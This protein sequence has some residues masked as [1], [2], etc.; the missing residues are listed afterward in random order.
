MIQAKSYVQ[1]DENGTL[2][3]GGLGVSLDSIAIAYRDGYSAETIQQL[4]PLLTL[5]EV[6]G[7]IAFYLANQKDVEE[8][9]SHQDSRWDDLR[10]QNEEQPSPV[11]SRLRSLAAADAAAAP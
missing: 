5:E 9:L 3:V 11:V 4:Y 10:R 6:Y 8:Y 7:G 2:R 1:A